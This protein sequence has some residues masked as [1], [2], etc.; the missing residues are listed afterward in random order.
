LIVNSLTWFCKSIGINDK[1]NIICIM[2]QSHSC[3]IQLGKGQKTLVFR[4]ITLFFMMVSSCYGRAYE[5]PPEGSS[6]VG[7]IQYHEVKK[8]ETIAKIAD[9]FDV[10]FLNVMAAN[11]DV[12]PFLPVPGTI[13]SMPTRIILPQV[14]QDGIVINLAELRL[15]YFNSDK[16][17]VFVFPVGI[18]RIGRDTPE[19]KT[20][21]SQKIPNPTWTPPLSIRQESLKRGK[22]LPM[23]VPAG[24]DNPL[25]KFALR[26]AHGQGDYLIH[27][28]NKN[29]GIG[30][31]VS[32]GCIRMNPQDI[33]WLFHQ[34]NVGEVVTVINEPV[35][36]TL[37]P[38][39]TVYLEVHEPLT[40]S[41]GSKK[42][43]SI[44]QSLD[45]W[46]TEYQLP[47]VRAKAVVLLQNGLPQEVAG[48]K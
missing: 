21:I 3:C 20:H 22:I 31:R 33:K 42:Q 13:L 35:K 14:Y 39:R 26:L 6:M 46:L 10:G 19:M 37:E 41:D 28:T 32:S 5:I 7:H 4:V 11:P 15:Y 30:L 36:V 38:D 34:V 25:G 29:F 27:G 40:R 9:E 16:N 17:K 23:I 18:G 12:D 47:D 43:V 1:G 45:W 48:L 24:P 8:G 44:P 2:Q